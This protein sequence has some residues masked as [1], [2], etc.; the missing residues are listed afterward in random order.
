[1][2]IRASRAAAC[3]GNE[4]PQCENLD[5]GNFSITFA[6]GFVDSFKTQQIVTEDENN[7]GSGGLN[8]LRN[9]ESI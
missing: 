8:A 5:D 9:D 1:M 2:C 3:T 6:E 7:S 4:W